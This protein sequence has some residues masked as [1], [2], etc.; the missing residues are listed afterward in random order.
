LLFIVPVKLENAL[1]PGGVAVI[2]TC[3]PAVYHP[4]DGVT[5]PPPEA[6]VVR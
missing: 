1:P 2:D 4:L 5:V 3:D 6:A